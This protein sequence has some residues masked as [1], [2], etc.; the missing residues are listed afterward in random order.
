[1]YTLLNDKKAQPASSARTHGRRDH[2][3]PHGRASD[4]AQRRVATARPSAQR[5]RC[6]R[7][8]VDVAAQ[9]R[10]RREH[11][12]LG[13]RVVAVG[14]QAVGNVQVGVELVV[15]AVRLQVAQASEELGRRL[16]RGLSAG[17]QAVEGDCLGYLQPKHTHD[18]LV[19]VG[20]RHHPF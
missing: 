16:V 10:R 5:C 11:A 4:G 13:L 3:K 19:E 15:V 1:M 12:L 2:K 17:P 14:C 6:A 18:C 7:H 20:M 8:D 9:R